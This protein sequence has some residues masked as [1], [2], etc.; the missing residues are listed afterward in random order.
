M[1]QMKFAS[2][3]DGK[4]GHP[5]VVRDAILAHHRSLPVE[6]SCPR[7]ERHGQDPGSGRP[8]QHEAS[9]ATLIKV[10]PQLAGDNILDVSGWEDPRRWVTRCGTLRRPAHS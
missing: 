4:A 2:G 5:L 7:R 1:D 6:R 10:V 3:F 9:A 8:D